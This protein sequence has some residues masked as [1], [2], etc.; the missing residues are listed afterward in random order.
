MRRVHALFQAHLER[1]MYAQLALERPHFAK[2]Y[3]W[4]S[5]FRTPLRTRVIERL[6]HRLIIESLK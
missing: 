3:E 6:S 5:S 2:A 4:L 1:G